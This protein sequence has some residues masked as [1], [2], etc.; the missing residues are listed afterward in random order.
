MVEE[1]IGHDCGSGMGTP[2]ASLELVAG[3]GVSAFTDLLRLAIGFA[4]EDIGF[5]VRFKIESVACIFI[6]LAKDGMRKFME[7]CLGIRCPLE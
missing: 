3:G 6:G 5:V 4:F 2:P 1:S 7:E